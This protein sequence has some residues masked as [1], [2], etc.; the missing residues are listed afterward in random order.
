MRSLLAGLISLAIV[1]PLL[2]KALDPS[3][4]WHTA[5]GSVQSVP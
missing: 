2:V 5:R 1:A 3:T 4:D